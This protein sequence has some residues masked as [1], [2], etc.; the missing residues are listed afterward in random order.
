MR[1]QVQSSLINKKLVLVKQNSKHSISWNT[2][3]LEE[4]GPGISTF[5]I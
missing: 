4:N 2:E 5:V 1:V 3:Y